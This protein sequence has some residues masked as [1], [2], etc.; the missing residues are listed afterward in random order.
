MFSTKVYHFRELSKVKNK[1][2]HQWKMGSHLSLF[3]PSSI[4]EQGFKKLVFLLKC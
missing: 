4:Q 1:E 3:L 2:H